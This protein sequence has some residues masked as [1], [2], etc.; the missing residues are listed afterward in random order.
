M[1]LNATELITEIKAHH[2]NRSDLTDELVVRALNL[3]QDRIARSYDFEELQRV[4]TGSFVIT[5]DET[6]DKFLAYTDIG[7]G[8]EPRKIYSFRVTATDGTHQKLERYTAR[9][10]DELIPRPEWYARGR[11][12][13]YIT[14]SDK[15]ELWRIPDSADPWELR[16]TIWPTQF[17]VADLTEFS[18]MKRKDDMLIHLTV[19]YL[20][21]K[22]SEYEK[23]GRFFSYFRAEWE[24]AVEEDSSRPDLVIKGDS[25]NVRFPPNDYWKDPFIRSIR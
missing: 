18:D 12:L 14:W 2:A 5:A 10:F 4:K 19:S 25:M 22:F 17:S 11:P 15:F 21:N 13:F 24:E 1:A 3:S 16:F 7:G 9:Q 23:A 20:Y 8:I 6:V